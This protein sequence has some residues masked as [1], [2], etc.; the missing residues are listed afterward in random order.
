MSEAIRVQAEITG[1]KGPAVNLMGALDPASGL[2]VVARELKLGERI[3]GVIVTSND[4]RSERRDR[5][6]TEDDLQEAIR[7]FFR[8]QSTGMIEL[9]PNVAKHEPA[10][11]I[12][13]DGIGENGTKYRLNPDITNGAIAVLALVAL[14]DGTFKAQSATDFC[15]DLADMFASI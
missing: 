9:L 11:R 7:L 6:F 2:L 1:Y 10:H 5:L 13:N 4:P 3:D 8:S 12:E 15:N 14:A